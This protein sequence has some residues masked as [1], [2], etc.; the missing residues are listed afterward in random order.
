MVFLSPFRKMKTGVN[1]SY[2]P[3]VQSMINQKGSGRKA[4][5]V[6]VVYHLDCEGFSAVLHIFPAFDFI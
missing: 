6:L 4:K 2:E 3:V 5:R 1:A